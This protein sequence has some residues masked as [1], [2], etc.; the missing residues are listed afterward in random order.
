[1]K[2]LYNINLEVVNPIPGSEFELEVMATAHMTQLMRKHVRNKKS[3]QHNR[4]M[5][6]M[7]K[8]KEYIKTAKYQSIADGYKKS[9][10]KKG[11]GKMKK[12]KGQTLPT[13]IAAN[14]ASVK[15]WSKIG[16]GENRPLK[17]GFKLFAIYDIT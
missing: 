15:S 3:H 7:Y 8:E 13:P 12:I 2:K 4:K 17:E 16:Y 10:S 5:N 1:M 14:D 6:K 11:K 9:M